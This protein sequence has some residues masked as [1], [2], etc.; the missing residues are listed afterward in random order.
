[1]F[2]R[3]FYQKNASINRQK[4]RGDRR[5]SWNYSKLTPF[6]YWSLSFAKFRRMHTK[7]LLKKRV[8]VRFGSFNHIPMVM[9]LAKQRY[10]CKNY[11]TDW[12][13]K[14]YFLRSNH[15]CTFKIIDWLSEKVP[16]TF[17]AKHCQVSLTTVIRTLNNLSY[18]SKNNLSKV[19]MVDEFR[20]HTST[21][22]KMSFICANER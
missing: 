21:E 7:S 12:I 10:A 1:M 5:F 8:L 19:L 22:Y 9:S 17:I 18:S 11:H 14:S 4:F 15:S 20:S 3:K 2:Y 13:A 16:I 6:N